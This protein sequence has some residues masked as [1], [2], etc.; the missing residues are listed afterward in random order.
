MRRTQKSF[1]CK[2]NDYL[3]VLE[4][5]CNA[6]GPSLKAASA[7][8]AKSRDGIFCLLHNSCDDLTCNIKIGE[9]V[10]NNVVCLNM[11]LIDSTSDAVKCMAFFPT[12]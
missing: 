1:S 11:F 3:A 2:E 12:K 7:V 5:F 8:S 4:N 6:T 9:N 10:Y